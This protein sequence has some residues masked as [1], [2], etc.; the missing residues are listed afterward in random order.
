[1]NPLSRNTCGN[2]DKAPPCPQSHR[3]TKD[4]KRTFDVLPKPDKLIS[5]R[6]PARPACPALG[7]PCVGLTQRCSAAS[8][9]PLIG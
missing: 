3:R 2:V 8:I 9:L 4:K 1:L 6:Q 5:Y 7:K